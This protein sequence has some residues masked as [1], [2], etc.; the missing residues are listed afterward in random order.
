MNRAWWRP[1][2]SSPILSAGVRR[3][4]WTAGCLGSAA[5]AWAAADTAGSGAGLAGWM[6]VLTLLLAGWIALVWRA[7]GAVLARLKEVAREKSRGIPS[8]RLRRV[9]LQKFIQLINLAARLTGLGLILGGVFVWATL[10]LDRLPETHPLAQR[11]EHALLEKLETLAIAAVATL[12]DLG[13]VALV[14]FATRIVHELLNHYF[15]SITDGEIAS[16]MFDAVTAETTRRL[17]DIGLWLAAVIIAFP[18]LPGSDSAAFRGVTVLGGLMLSLGSANLVGQF[19]NGLAIIYSRALRPGDYIE[20][21]QAEGTVERIGW[22]ACTLRTCRNEVVTLPHS[23]VAAGLKNYSRGQGGVRCAATVTI[24]YDVSWR[25]VRE[26]LLAAAAATPGV[27]DTPAPGVR[28]AGLDDFYVRY[29]LLF[30]PDDP[31]ERIPILGRL[32]EAIQDRFHAAGV[33]IMSPHYMA[34]PAA[35]KVP[36]AGPRAEQ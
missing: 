20:S 1:V 11:I 22:F 4:R 25:Q 10:M 28:Q 31:A 17:A 15:R 34:D 9:S 33:Q 16:G 23:A 13:V 3:A 6:T 12:P 36:P 7:R 30:T 18:Y 26:L 5:P 8:A 27:R 14:F 19:A 24:G 2:M 35:P 29:E 32:H 21:G